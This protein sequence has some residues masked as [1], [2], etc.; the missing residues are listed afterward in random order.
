M[1]WEAGDVR[2]LE[3]DLMRGLR[4]RVAALVTL[5]GMSALGCAPSDGG[6]GGQAATDCALAVRLD[7]MQYVEYG[8]TDHAASKWGQAEDSACDDMGRNP[9]GSYFPG[10]PRRVDVWS[11]DGQDPRKVLGVRER[12]GTLRVFIAQD[13]GRAK[14]GA[15]VEALGE[16]SGR[17]ER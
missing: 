1:A 13:V 16:P 6:A 15:I 4:D 17:Q 14:A 2:Q 9:R 12:T 5:L 8:F 10:N 7:G 3:V 11:F